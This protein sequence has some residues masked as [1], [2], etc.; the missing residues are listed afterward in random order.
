MQRLHRSVCAVALVGI[1]LALPAGTCEAE[2][3]CSRRFALMPID[4]PAGQRTDLN[5]FIGGIVIGTLMDQTLG[6]MAGMPEASCPKI[7]F[8]DIEA[9][10]RAQQL[11][12]A[13]AAAHARQRNWTIPEPWTAPPEW[14][15][16]YVF[17]ATLT[18]DRVTGATEWTCEEGY[19]PGTEYC[20]GG[21]LEGSFTFTLALV[22]HHHKN[23]ILEQSSVSWDGNILEGLG[24]W[25]EGGVDASPIRQVVNPF[26]PLQTLIRDYERLPESA[27][28]TVPEDPLGAG[29]TVTITLFDLIDDQ[30]RLS[31]P[32]QRILVKVDK[33][34]VVNGEPDQEVTEGHCV[35]RAGNE[36]IA[37]VQ[38]RA[39]EECVPQRETLTVYNTCNKIEN[40]GVTKRSSAPYT[41]LARREFDI[42]CDQWDV[43]ITYTE[44]VDGEERE[45]DK[46]RTV[47]RHYAATFKARVRLAEAD[48]RTS[49]YR[50]EDCSVDFHD[51]YTWHYIDNECNHRGGFT[52]EKVGR[53]PVPIE[54]QF[55]PGSQRYYFRFEPPSEVISYRFAGQ[56]LGPDQH[57]T[58]A[59]EYEAPSSWSVLPSD[60]EETIGQRQYTAGQSRL[61]GDAIL[62]G[63][64][65]AVW[66]DNP[67]MFEPSMRGD[68]MQ[69]IFMMNAQIGG[70]APMVLVSLPTRQTLAWEIKRPE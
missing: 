70:Y 40:K 16:D 49:V 14:D 24:F 48:S 44:D 30:G 2:T 68:V 46:K 34:T 10:V 28:V 37:K 3:C 57:C 43:T 25:R 18:A 32:W 45:G 33:G 9:K 58:G 13:I 21:H 5:A 23:A 22:D 61:A 66:P 20:T 17:R 36:G 29:E 63:G 51:N 54:V 26:M 15:L 60:W 6:L 38:Y 59:W 52:G 55:N 56:L 64:V 35:F 7:E 12:D 1:L 41:E 19:D 39:P 8:Y 42:V 27:K 50:S 4:M 62:D 31:Q 11:A 47:S 65:A 67:Q 53:V 69:A